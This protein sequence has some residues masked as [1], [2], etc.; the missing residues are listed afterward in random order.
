MSYVVHNIVTGQQ[1]RNKLFLNRISSNQERRTDQ[2]NG[3]EEGEMNLKGV[4]NVSSTEKTAF[5]CRRFLE[6]NALVLKNIFIVVA[7]FSVGILYYYYR[8]GWELAM[9]LYFIVV[10]SKCQQAI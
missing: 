6:D 8:E 9:S 7:Y 1:S 4:K 2:D 3:S 10:S 5:H